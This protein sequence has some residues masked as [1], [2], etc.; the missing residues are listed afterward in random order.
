M[1]RAVAL[2]SAIAIAVIVATA[3]SATQG[4]RSRALH[5]TKD[6]SEYHGAVGEFCTITSSN[7]RA[8][9]PGMKV[10]YLAALPPSG[11]L[12]SD[13][14]LSSGNGGAALGHVVLDLGAA[15]G[16]VTFS[17]GTGRFAGFHARAVVSADSKGVWHWDGT[18]KFNRSGD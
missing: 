1:K 9:K 16:R 2:V 15:Q 11:M 13:L 6:C 12:D 8:I 18:Y 10:V 14:V 5:V 4:Q 3:G 7:V 17:V